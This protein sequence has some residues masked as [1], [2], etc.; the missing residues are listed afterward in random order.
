MTK[1][2]SIRSDLGKARGLG[3]AKEG[4][5]HWWMQRVSA[6]ALIPLS[7]FWLCSLKDIVNP[8]LAEF[9]Q[10]ISL[11]QNAIAGVLF[12]LTSFYHA[13]LGMQVIIEDYVHGEGARIASLLVNK[14]AFFFLGTACVCAILW[15]SLQSYVSIG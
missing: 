1:Q 11:P 2:A 5:G 6:V 9:K 3:S 7:L 13:A 4:F 10:W 8:N 12:V 14:I 15:L